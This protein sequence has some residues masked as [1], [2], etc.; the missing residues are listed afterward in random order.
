MVNLT[1]LVER[2]KASPLPDRAIDADIA[3]MLKWK[4]YN[5]TVSGPWVDMPGDYDPRNKI[6]G[7][8][9]AKC[10]NWSD[11]LDECDR[12]FNYILADHRRVL[13]NRAYV[14]SVHQ[15]DS[16][17]QAIIYHP[18]SSGGPPMWNSVA[19]TGPLAY[20]AAIVEAFAFLTS[21]E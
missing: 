12:L 17:Q 5:L 14:N 1:R 2:I 13:Y 9:H 21:Q 10:P 6:E 3:R 8:I 16:V 4:V 18:L 7:Y 20:L 11:S 19:K 15:S